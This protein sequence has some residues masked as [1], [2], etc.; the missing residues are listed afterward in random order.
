MTMLF[1]IA[2]AKKHML[3]RVFHLSLF[4]AEVKLSKFLAFQIQLFEMHQTAAAAIKVDEVF[5]NRHGQK[6]HVIISF[7]CIVFDAEVKLS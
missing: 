1:P 4:D 5:A 3:L 2:L 7:S 6:L